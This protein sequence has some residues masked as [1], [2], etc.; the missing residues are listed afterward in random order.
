[1]KAEMHPRKNPMKL[2][3]KSDTSGSIGDGDRDIRRNATVRHRHDS[4][5]MFQNL[6]ALFLSVLLSISPP[7]LLGSCEE[8]HKQ[9]QSREEHAYQGEPAGIRH[10]RKG[11][12]R[13]HEEAKREADEKNGSPK[14]LARLHH[15][16]G[17]LN[18][19]KIATT[20]LNSPVPM[21]KPVPSMRRYVRENDTPT[22]AKPTK[23]NR[24]AKRF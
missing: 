7:V 16:R 4:R 11:E 17:L 6:I 22:N 18:S 5:L 21:K 15:F 8:Q 10:A 3:W 14:W 12:N 2:Q 23:A 13:I 24:S 1:M 9:E 19:K 20:K